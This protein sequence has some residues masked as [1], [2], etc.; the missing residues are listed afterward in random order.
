MKSVK[1]FSLVGRRVRQTSDSFGGC[2]NSFEDKRGIVCDV[3]WTA[4][5]CFVVL[6]MR[7]DGSMFH[8][9][10]DDVNVD[11][12]VVASLEPG[13]E[14]EGDAARATMGQE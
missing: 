10:V 8:A 6:V 4:A 9:V 7:D 2:L 14:A 12:V 1:K 11:D 13:G 5:G 3:A